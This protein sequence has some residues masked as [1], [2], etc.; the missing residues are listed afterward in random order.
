[1]RKK[2]QRSVYA[3]AIMLVFGTMTVLAVL[4]LDPSSAVAQ[5]TTG[6][7][8]QSYETNSTGISQGALL[9]LTSN[10]ITAV[11]PASSSSASHL[12]GIAAS[13]PLVELSSDS[14]AR[15]QHRVQVV[16]SGSTDALVSDLNGAVY[17]G[18]KITASPV[19]GVGMKAIRAGEIVGI[20]QASLS[21]VKTVTETFDGTNGEPVAAKVGLL[22]I[23]VNVAYYSAAPIGGSLAA[24]VP[25]F[26]QSLANSIAGKAVSPLRVLTGTV[27]LILG[28]VTIA[29]MLYAGIRSGVISLGRNPLAA[30]TLRKGMVDIL[31]TAVGILVVTGVI[32]TAVIAA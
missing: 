2:L 31:I 1:M 29:I 17:A 28:F 6:A 12:V 13:K 26:L 15:S 5:S 25:P 7:I 8:S 14:N 30:D 11:A 9:S 22:P 19:S 23:A 27:A 24:F 3:G 21:S 4:I 18:D 20:A 10:G 16:V 32:V